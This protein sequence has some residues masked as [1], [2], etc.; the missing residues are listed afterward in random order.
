MWLA[1]C[2]KSET[3]EAAQAGETDGADGSGGMPTRLGFL[4]VLEVRRW[5]EGTQVEGVG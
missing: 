4:L 1:S 2:Y 5:P 3:G